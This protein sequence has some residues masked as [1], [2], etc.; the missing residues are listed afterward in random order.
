MSFGI[1][2]GIGG[3]LIGASASRSASK[4]AAASADKATASQED[5]TRERLDFD[6]QT[7][8]DGAGDRA[9]A[10]E[11]ARTTARSQAEDRVKYNALQD[12]QI[13]R[14]RKFQGVE[15]R[16]LVDADEYDTEGKREQMASAAMADVNKGFANAQAQQQRGLA[17]MGVNPNSGKALALGNQTAIAQAAGLAGAANSA[18]LKAETTGYAR[19][20]DAVGLGKGVIGNQATQAGLTLQSGNSSVNNALVP[21]NVMSSASDTMS[22]GLGNA[23]AGFG[24]L[25]TTQRNNFY[26]AQQYG[27]GV[28]QSVGNMFGSLASNPGVQQGLSGF[29]KPAVTDGGYSIGQ[30]SA[31]GGS[32]AGL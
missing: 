23:A 24:N 29:F 3:A 10:S 15:D 8:A 22:R 21:F 16:M 27:A 32:R 1:V 26:D 20:M 4:K 28:G 13:V 2:A 30:G 5:A 11:M 12:E 14:G 18:R 17:R 25:A 6:K 31:Y 7:Y 9:F 19:K